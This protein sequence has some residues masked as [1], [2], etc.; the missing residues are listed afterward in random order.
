MKIRTGFVSNSSASSFIIDKK[1]ISS[2][3]RDLI[4]NHLEEARKR[5]KEGDYH[6]HCFDEW[7]VNETDTHI[8]CSTS[9]D[10]FDM[11]HYLTR[12]VGVNSSDIIQ[13]Y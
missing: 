13:E 5:E 11:Y 10:N 3:Q 1:N 6:T 12:I 8:N 4:F 2:F 7:D 9:M